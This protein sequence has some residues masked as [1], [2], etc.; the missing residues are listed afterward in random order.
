VFA[1]YQSGVQ[2]T[3]VTFSGES[4]SGQAQLSPREALVQIRQALGKLNADGTYGSDGVVEPRAPG[5][6][7]T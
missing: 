7:R 2:I 1:D 6:V 5:Y 3:Q 4:Q